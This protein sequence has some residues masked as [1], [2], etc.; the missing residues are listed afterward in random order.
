MRPLEEKRTVRHLVEAGLNASQI[1]YVAAIP[2]ST[3][4]DWLSS[5]A[6]E[7]PRSSCTRCGHPEHDFTALPESE[8]AYLLGFYLGDGTISAG[9]KGVYALAA[10]WGRLGWQTPTAW[11]NEWGS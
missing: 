9:R 4:R 5:P 6:A 7:D 10:R 1:A 11:Q 3:V 8:Y 2:R